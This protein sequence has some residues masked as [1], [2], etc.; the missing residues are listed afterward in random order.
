MFASPPG[1]ALERTTQPP[2][3]PYVR[4]TAPGLPA[5]ASN[6]AHLR[7]YLRASAF[8]THNDC[9]RTPF[10]KKSKQEADSFYLSEAPLHP[11]AHL[12]RHVRTCGCVS[13]WPEPTC[14]IT[15]AAN[16]HFMLWNG[17]CSESVFFFKKKGSSALCLSPLPR[18]M[19]S[20]E[21]QEGGS[22]TEHRISAS[23]GFMDWRYQSSFYTY[24]CCILMIS[25]MTQS[26]SGK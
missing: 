20:A 8:P 14:P 26:N 22:R 9:W 15:T 18:F 12:V 23:P 5:A 4:E 19:I 13:V 17:H 3:L 16:P 21:P 25:K 10:L 7:R 2:A 24:G 6:H 1:A 11:A